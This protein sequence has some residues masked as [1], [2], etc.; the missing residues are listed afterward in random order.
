MPTLQTFNQSATGDGIVDQG[1]ANGSVANAW[2]TKLTDGTNTTAVKAASTAPV[3]TDPAA[4]VSLSPNG[5]QATA[6]LQTA[7][8]ASLTSIDAGIPTALGANTS[9]NSMPVV[10][11]LTSTS[12]YKA[13][14]VTT[15]AT[16]AIGGSSALTNRRMIIITPTNGTVYWGTNSSVTTATGQP[17]V[18]FNQLFLDVNESVTIYLI[19]TATTDVRVTELS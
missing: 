16:L 5:N 19:G 17:L 14:S 18:S 2:P 4:V 3:A 9:P 1:A 12:Q 10:D 7:G 11:I 8:N 15:S 13:L 6:A